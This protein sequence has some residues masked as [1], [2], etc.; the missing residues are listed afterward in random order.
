[1]TGH[2]FWLLTTLFFLTAYSLARDVIVSPDTGVDSNTGTVT[3]PL[4]TAE[5]A[6]EATLEPTEAGKGL[7]HTFPI[8]RDASA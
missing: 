3:A 1:M 8:G 6:V 5:G 4:A 7:Y 2:S